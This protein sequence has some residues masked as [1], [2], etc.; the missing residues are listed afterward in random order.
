MLFARKK[1]V[2][3]K[4][5]QKSSSHKLQT[6][7]RNII[8]ERK[9]NEYLGDQTKFCARNYNL[10]NV[11]VPRLRKIGSFISGYGYL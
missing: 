4:F 2:K 1:V 10:P 5:T 8:T 6:S 11:V 9:L 7:R 3:E